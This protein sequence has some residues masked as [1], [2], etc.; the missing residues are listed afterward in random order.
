MMKSSSRHVLIA[1]NERLERAVGAA[2]RLWRR[3]GPVSRPGALVVEVAFAQP[4]RIDSSTDLWVACLS[5]TAWLTREG[6]RAD[7]I[8]SPGDV[9]R[10]PCTGK[11]LVVGMPRCRLRIALQREHLA[12]RHDTPTT[13]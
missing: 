10:V 6:C 1:W 5:G 3:P 9:R 12:E 4:Y 11:P 2:L 13:T 7:T 8:L